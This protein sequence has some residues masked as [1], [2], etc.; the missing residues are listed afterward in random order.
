MNMCVYD[1]KKLRI[2]ILYMIFLIDLRINFIP[3]HN[4]IVFS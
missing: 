1:I 2:K 3:C 4:L